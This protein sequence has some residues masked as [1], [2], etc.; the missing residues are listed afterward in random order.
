MSNIDDL[1]CAHRTSCSSLITN[2][3]SP[4][5][6][7]LLATK[8]VSG[9][10][11]PLLK[12]YARIVKCSHGSIEAILPV[13]HKND[14][15]CYSEYACVATKYEKN[16]VLHTRTLLRVRVKSKPER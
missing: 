14:I 2:R 11:T 4:S 8:V 3:L 5:Y 16:V 13:H 10:A 12:L 9:L 15:N 1:S 6:I 7:A